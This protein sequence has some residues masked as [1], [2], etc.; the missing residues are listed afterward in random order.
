MTNNKN[1]EKKNPNNNP[2]TKKDSNTDNQKHKINNPPSNKNKEKN[3]TNITSNQNNGTTGKSYNQ[4]E[5]LK[6]INTLKKELELK[7]TLIT[8]F[9]STQQGCRMGKHVVR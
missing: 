4:T 8:I 1:K 3:N 7:S 2:L 6:E 9:L 5:I